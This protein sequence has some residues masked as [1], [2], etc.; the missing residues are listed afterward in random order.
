MDKNCFDLSRLRYWNH[1]TAPYSTLK[2]PVMCFA[3]HVCLFV[4]LIDQFAKGRIWESLAF[5]RGF[6]VRF[7]TPV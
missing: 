2:A 7:D 5:T 3:K 4:T 6:D 1:H